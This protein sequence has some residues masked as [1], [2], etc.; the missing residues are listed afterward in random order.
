[1]LVAIARLEGKVDVV[2]A[3]HDVRL[4]AVERES[5]DHDGRIRALEA[6]PTVSPRA[7]W[8]A[9]TSGA[10]LVFGVIT[11]INNLNP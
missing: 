7:L 2:L 8:A 4:S 9:V 11:L 1:M 3:R 10:A 5:A 6:R